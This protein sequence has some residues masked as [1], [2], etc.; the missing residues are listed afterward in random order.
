MNPIRV[1]IVEDDV[2]VADL[3]RQFTESCRG[4]VVTKVAHTGAEALEFI[5]NNPVDLV[6]LDI[7]LPD[8]HGIDVLKDIR[9]ND[10]PIDILLITAAHDADTVEESI[11]SGVFDY[12]IK[13]F[14]VLRYKNSLNNY[15][16]YRKS[17]ES[18]S[19]IDQRQVDNVMAGANIQNAAAEQLPKGIN[20]TTME[21]IR[22][23]LTPL[24]GEIGIDDICSAVPVSR[25]TAYRYLEYLSQRGFLEK[26]YR[27][28]QRGRPQTIYTRKRSIEHP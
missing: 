24:Q 13:P 25:I 14:D 3:N 8:M 21:L 7:Y 9:K 6:V 28:Q 18:S 2:M 5:D 16:N 17:L 23:A 15:L 4:F 1:M 11:R 27:Y 12:I 26:N 20:T 10:Y 22:K 19:V